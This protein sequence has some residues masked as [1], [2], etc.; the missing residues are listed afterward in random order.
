[1][2]VVSGD[3]AA[4]W[5]HDGD[6]AVYAG[7]TEMFDEGGDAGSDCGVGCCGTGV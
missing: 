7:G 3:Y 2:R 6:A 1:M 4:Q 5:R